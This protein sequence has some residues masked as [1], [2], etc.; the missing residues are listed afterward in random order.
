MISEIMQGRLSRFAGTAILVATSLASVGCASVDQAENFIKVA[1]LSVVLLF[2]FLFGCVLLW[3]VIQRDEIGTLIEENGGGASMSRFQF[4]IFT[5]VVAFGIVFLLAK[6]DKFP[7]IPADVLTLI[8]ISASTY[9]VS[10][11]ITAGSNLLPKGD[12]ANANAH[13]ANPPERR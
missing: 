7:A 1:A 9:A 3:K 8:G 6:G 10:K 4:L 12:P 13:N 11:G 2:L 5:F